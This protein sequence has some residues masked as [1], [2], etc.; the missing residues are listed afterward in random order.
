MEKRRVGAVR[1][2]R[3]ADLG[4]KA[5]RAEVAEFY[6]EGVLVEG[7][8]L[9]GDARTMVEVEKRMAMM[10]GLSGA[11]NKKKKGPHA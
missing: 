1:G 11:R 10:T 6:G 7:A 4:D 3:S 8:G 9:S 5:R 2:R